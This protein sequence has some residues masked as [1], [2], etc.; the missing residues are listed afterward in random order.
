[1]T[2]YLSNFEVI[3]LDPS[4]D[5]LVIDMF[6]GTSSTLVPNNI[7]SA[8]LGS[9]QA[10]HLFLKL[11][12]SPSD[13]YPVP[14]V[15][16]AGRTYNF[17]FQFCIPQQTLP[18]AS[19]HF[20][21][22]DP[23]VQHHLQ[24]PPS[25]GRKRGPTPSHSA[26]DDL[27]PAMLSIYYDIVAEL[28]DDDGLVSGVS[29]NI[30][31]VPLSN[32]EPPIYAE[33]NDDYRLKEERTTRTGTLGRKLG[34]LAMEAEPP[35]AIPYMELPRRA[36]TDYTT[37]VDVML[38]FYP[39]SETAKPPRIGTSKT[40]IWV[41]NFYAFSIRTRIPTAH[42]AMLDSRQ[43]VHV[44]KVK[45]PT[46]NY[47][48]LSWQRVPYVPLCSSQPETTGRGKRHDSIASTFSL[49]SRRD[50]A[51]AEPIHSYIARLEIPIVLPDHKVFVP[52]FHSCL[53]SRTYTLQFLLEVAGSSSM[54]L[55]V[56]VQIYH[57]PAELPGQD[58]AG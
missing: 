52:T 12:L 38:R 53:V 8:A 3:V 1:L 32:M 30:R 5:L 33:G 25:L 45:L 24:L 14:R 7:P 44:S 46:V 54:E 20:M 9:T 43:G 42:D 16:R 48:D 18:R 37:M 15:L 6:I 31:V 29:A 21:T 23:V 55:R 13:A 22:D 19:K 26:Y 47:D 17:D 56:P 50:A 51:S 34:V 11:E 39:V 35:E 41:S 4:C 28:S 10:D 27:A 49:G 57:N 36:G 2:S 58:P 40:R